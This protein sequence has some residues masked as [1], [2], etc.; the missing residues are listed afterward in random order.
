MEQQMN[1]N[2]C[3]FAMP[4]VDFD[5]CNSNSNSNSNFNLCPPMPTANKAVRISKIS[6]PDD[7]K[8]FPTVAVIVNITAGSSYDPLFS[9]QPQKVPE[10]KVAVYSVSH[11]SLPLL[12]KYSGEKI[13]SSDIQEVD[14]TV[15]GLVDQLLADISSV[16][17]DSVVFNFE[18]CSSCSDTSVGTQPAYFYK[19]VKFM[20][21]AKHMVMCSDFSLKG[22]IGTWDAEVMGPCPV[23]KVGEFSSSCTL[24]FNCQELK[25]GP[26]AQLATVADLCVNGEANVKAMGGTILF[27]VLSP[28]PKTDEYEVSVL[29]VM[30]AAD[31]SRPASSPAATYISRDDYTGVA[32]HVALT[33][34]SGGVLLLSAGHW[35][36]LAR[37][38]TSLDNLKEAV[39]NQMGEQEYANW[40][41]AY[42]AAPVAE[43]ECMMQQKAAECVWASAPC[44]YSKAG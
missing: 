37:L 18:C 38:D 11:G 12:L 16:N 25:D 8:D 23:A 40:N 26:S 7:D 15:L 20:L 32:G 22:L 10:G 24:R 3:N 17:A 27:N 13:P 29:T 28:L 34:K 33:Y 2:Y 14:D 43:Q 4:N 41:M 39:I 35:I 30:T 21:D 6:Q 31:G 1:S 9:Q 5:M 44:K 36:E 19:F 42:N